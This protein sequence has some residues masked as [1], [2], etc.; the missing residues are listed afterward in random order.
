MPKCIVCMIA[1]KEIP[2]DIVYEDDQ[3]LAFRDL[4][5]QAP[6]HVLIV[7]KKHIASLDNMTQEDQ[8][9]MGYLMYNVPDIAKELELGNC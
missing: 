3:I 7:P 5:P 4:E 9:L 6:V 8:A 1:N 2:S